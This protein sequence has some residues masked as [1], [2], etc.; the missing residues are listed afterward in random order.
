MARYNY[1]RRMSTKQLISLI[2]GILLTMGCVF[3][4]VNFFGADTRTISPSA[5]SV[6][7]LNASGE[8]V[9]QESTIFTEDLIEC[10]GLTITPDLKTTSYYKVFLYGHDKQF[11]ESTEALRSIYKL[12]NTS[13]QYCR[14]VIY[15]QNTTEDDATLNFFDIWGVAKEFK[16]EVNRKQSFKVKDYFEPAKTNKVATSVYGEYV[17]KNGYGASK[18]ANIEGLTELT[19]LYDFAQPEAIEILFFT[20]VEGEEVTYTYVSTVTTEVES[21]VE[22]VTIPSGATH[23]IVNYKLSEGIE[24]NGN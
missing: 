12:T 20:E 18:M 14:I 16:I 2:L 10:Q 5:F 3:G 6:G 4:A 15:P 9:D 7:G 11:I 19:V 17:E 8:Y 1:R 23:M 24:I 22:T 13:A 21:T